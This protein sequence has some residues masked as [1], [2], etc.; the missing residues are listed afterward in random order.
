MLDKSRPRRHLDL[1]GGCNVRDIGGYATSNGP[2]T[3]WRTFLR[4]GSMHRLTPA[5]QAALVDYGLRTVIDLRRTR[6]VEEMPN[7]F[8]ESPREIYHH[9][10]MIGDDPLAGKND[11]V[12]TG[13]YAEWIV[14]SY[15]TWLELRQPQIGQTLATLAEPGALPAV[16]HCAGGKDRTGIISALLLGIAGVPA[17]TI[18][19]DYALSARYLMDRYFAEWAPSGVTPSNYTWED[20]QRDF[21]PPEAMLRVLGHLDERYGGIEEYVRQIGLGQTQID[22]L[23][24]AL[25]E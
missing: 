6:E 8:A 18:A 4:S 25:V 17:E 10:N 7:V 5:S 13:E 1:E 24:A 16:Y 3:R 15:S 2:A 11:A 19:E 12:E 9:Q 23:R 20:Y 22:G 14:A 21:C